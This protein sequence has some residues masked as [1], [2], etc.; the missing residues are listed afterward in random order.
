MNILLDF[1]GI[2]FRNKAFTRIIEKKSIEFV[3]KYWNVSAS[4]SKFL[5]KIL[6]KKH[7]H[8]ANGLAK[9]TKNSLPDVIKDYNDYV[10]VKNVKHYEFE[11]LLNKDDY[12]RFDTLS[13]YMRNNMDG[14]Y[15]LFTNA[16]LVW[17]ET[18]SLMIGYD[19]S[20]IIDYDKVFTSDEGLLKPNMDAYNNVTGVL[21]SEEKIHFIDD[22]VLNI[23]PV[24]NLENWEG[25]HINS[26]D[27]KT[28]VD[29]LKTIPDKFVVKQTNV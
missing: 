10:F 21:S 24:F 11:G 15:G 1:D 18:V 13:H 8:T 22:S 14:K 16:P 3:E 12:V 20:H 7:G 4:H 19:L 28:I 23:E 9:L 6:Y 2:I 26:N 5:N 25:Y 29:A 17:C 27:P